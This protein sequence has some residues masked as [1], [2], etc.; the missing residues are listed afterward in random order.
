MWIQP[1]NDNSAADVGRFNC[2]DGPRVKAVAWR[3]TAE[4]CGAK[5]I[6]TSAH[7]NLT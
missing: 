1:D 2:C 4:E 6:N 7:L 3:N 5:I